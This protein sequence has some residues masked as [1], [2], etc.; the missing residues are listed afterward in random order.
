MLNS[1]AWL[2]LGMFIAFSI[3]GFVAFWI[4]REQCA[5]T[6]T[7]TLM[8]I[9][10]E[11]AGRQAYEIYQSEWLVYVGPD[12]SDYFRIVKGS[13]SERYMKRRWSDLSERERDYWR[14]V[15]WSIGYS[16]SHFLRPWF[17]Q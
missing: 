16:W 7:G 3:V 1:F 2:V 8:T 9:F 6:S 10:Q 13:E 17:R 14:K 11:R 5:L 15:A 4:R 12:P